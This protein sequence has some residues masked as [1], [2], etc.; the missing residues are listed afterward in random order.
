VEHAAYPLASGAVVT[1]VS[2]ALVVVVGAD[3]VVAPVVGTTSAGV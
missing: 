3:G 1:A 2:G